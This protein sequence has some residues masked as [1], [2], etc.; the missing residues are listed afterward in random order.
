MRTVHIKATRKHSI[1]EMARLLVVG[2][3]AKIVAVVPTLLTIFAD[4]PLRYEV[5]EADVLVED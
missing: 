4:S 1:G 2:T 5:T 3:P